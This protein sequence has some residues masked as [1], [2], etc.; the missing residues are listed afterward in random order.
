MCDTIADVSKNG[1]VVKKFKLQLI[2]AWNGIWFLDAQASQEEMIVP[3]TG[4]KQL[5]PNLPYL[6]DLRDL[7]DLQDQ[8]QH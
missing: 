7:P 8:Q 1:S 4:M 2:Y 5:I 6:S 3:D